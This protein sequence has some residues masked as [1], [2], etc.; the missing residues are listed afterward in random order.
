VRKERKGN[1]EKRGNI[2]QAVR[3]GEK[4]KLTTKTKRGADTR[5]QE[6]KMETEHPT[7][8]K[9]ILARNKLK[10]EDGKRKIWQRKKIHQATANELLIARLKK[11]PHTQEKES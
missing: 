1:A 6:V 2:I 11:P 3:E 4:N 8:Q 7:P 5:R 9:N 10:P